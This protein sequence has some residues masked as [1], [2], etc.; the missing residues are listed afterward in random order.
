MAGQLFRESGTPGWAV[1]EEA[2]PPGPTVVDD[3]FANR[4]PEEGIEPVLHR[5]NRGDLFTSLD[6]IDRDVR[7]SDRA[8]LA[9]LLEID[10]GAQALFEGHVGIYGVELV[11]SDLLDAECLE[12]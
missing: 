11:E 8:D 1:G 9:R 4:L 12:R 5:G 6:L 2:D 10:H 7:Q 3:A